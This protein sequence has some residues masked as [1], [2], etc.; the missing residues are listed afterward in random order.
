MLTT[1]RLHLI[2]FF[3]MLLFT[4]VLSHAQE[5]P[6]LGTYSG[7][8]TV[9]RMLTAKESDGTNLDT[10]LAKSV[11]KIRGIAFMQ[12]GDTHPRLVFVSAFKP[13]VNTADV[14]SMVDFSTTPPTLTN[15]QGGAVINFPTITVEGK[16]VTITLSGGSG[17]DFIGTSAVATYK[18]TL[19]K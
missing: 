1:A 18:L 4:P 16:K 7:T 3:T 19:D 13:V 17:D 8:L 11:S 14:Y 12:T 6:K 15:A 2:A 9:K 5:V 10:V